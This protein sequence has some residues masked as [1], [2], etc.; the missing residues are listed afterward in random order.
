MKIVP[1]KDS[2]EHLCITEQNLFLTETFE[3]M[4]EWLI[5]KNSQVLH[6]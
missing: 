5:L 1:D 3:A 2:A 6:F 4:I